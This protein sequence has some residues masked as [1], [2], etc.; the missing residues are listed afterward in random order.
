MR[1]GGAVLEPRSLAG[2][3][4]GATGAGLQAGARGQAK[5]LAA[6]QAGPALS[7]SKEPALSLSKDR[8]VLILLSY[9][10]RPVVARA[11]QEGG[12]SLLAHGA[13]DARHRPEI[14]ACGDPVPA[15]GLAA[16][17]DVEV[18]RHG[19]IHAAVG[20]SVARQLTI[21]GVAPGALFALRLLDAHRPLIHA[22]DGTIRPLFGRVDQ[23]PAL[24]LVVEDGPPLRL[25]VGRVAHLVA[26]DVK[27]VDE[28]EEPYLPLAL[29]FVVDDDLAQVEILVKVHR[30]LTHQCQRQVG[31]LQRDLGDKGVGRSR[32]CAAS[33]R[34]PPSG[35][36]RPPT[37]QNGRDGQRCGSPG[38]RGAS[39]GR[40][41]GRSGRS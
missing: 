23:K 2:R 34:R 14:L 9:P 3:A 6:Q 36:A 12:R 27:V 11:F 15:S 21:F 41:A 40:A 30:V 1:A 7:L 22:E 25:V 24:A 33:R 38:P 13:V 4:M 17:R 28:E 18:Q 10:Q 32:G 35:T 20:H 19:R 16:G 29:R 39:T 26:A 31:V 8:T 5:E 37:R